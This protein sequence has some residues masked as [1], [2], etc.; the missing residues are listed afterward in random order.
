M[1]APDYVSQVRGAI[2]DLRANY[3]QKQELF[4]QQQQAAANLQLQYAQLAQQRDNAE[5]QNQIEMARLQASAV[6]QFSQQLRDQAAAARQDATQKLEEA[7]IKLAQDREANDLQK[8]REA[9]ERD[10]TANAL[11]A[12]YKIAFESNDSKKLELVEQ[13]IAESSITTAQRTALY[14]NVQKRLE[15]K[16]TLEQAQRNQ[17]TMSQASSLITSIGQ[18]DPSQMLPSQYKTRVQELGQQ[19]ADLGNNDAKMVSGFQ[20]AIA[21]A[22][23]RGNTFRQ[24]VRGAMVENM[25]WLGE[26]RSSAR[27]SK[28]D[29]QRYDDLDKAPGGRNFANLY[30]LAFDLQRRASEKIL[31]EMRNRLQD[32]ITT[33]IELNPSLARKAVDPETKEETYYYLNPP[34]D[35]LPVIGENGTIDPETGEITKDTIAAI[36]KW[37]A[38]NS[39]PT[40]V[41]ME[42]PIIRKLS[43]S[44]VVANPNW[45]NAPPSPT[46]SGTTTVQVPPQ[47]SPLPADKINQ[48]VALYNTNPNAMYAGRPVREIV[49]RLQAQGTPLPG[50]GGTSTA[51]GQPQTR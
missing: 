3:L 32:K 12:E 15:D 6:N 19:F 10:K 43:R 11:E 7:R 51:T 48:I 26:Q 49:A 45:R 1:A 16:R 42:P 20:R 38:R 28:E 13:K 2:N 18:L 40:Y 29:Q 33:M 30:G 21:E 17:T 9:K 37:E 50:L 39:S 14:A 23:E 35:L 44:Q 31:S 5:R 36:D 47:A 41:G 22:I 8:E 24:S 25:Q 34:P 27:L 46:A 4:Q